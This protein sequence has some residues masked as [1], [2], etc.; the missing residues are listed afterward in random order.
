M[1]GRHTVIDPKISTK[2]F[3]G[4]SETPGTFLDKFFGQIFWTIFKKHLWTIYLDN[5]LDNFQDN[6]SDNRIIIWT[7]LND[8]EG[9]S[10]DKFWDNV[11]DNFVNN[12][13]DNFG[14][15]FRDNFRENFRDNLNIGLN[16]YLAW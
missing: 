14:D 9:N 1:Y 15:N 4:F 8:F 13:G 11:M 7:F 12:F 16:P 6:I 5:I 2:T 3:L 10:R